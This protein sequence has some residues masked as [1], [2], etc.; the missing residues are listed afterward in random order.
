MTAYL[1]AVRSEFA[2]FFS[3]RS[4]WILL[5]VMVGYLAAIAGIIGFVVGFASEQLSTGGQPAE[6]SGAAGVVYS[7]AT[8]MGYVFPLLIGALAV[9][10]EFRHNTLTPTFLAIPRRG[11]VLAGKATALA[12]V[13]AGYGIAALIGTMGAGSALLAI[14]GVDTE[15]GST[16]TWAMVGRIILAMALWAV[17]GVGVGSI[18]PNQV[19]SIVIVLALTQFIEPILRMGSMLSE[20]TAS[21]SR[22]LPGSASDSLVG[23]SIYTLMSGSAHPNVTPLEWWQGGVVLAAIALVLLVIGA[24]T[25]WRRDLD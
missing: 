10:G 14:G 4:W 18:V 17:V 12:I 9:T 21:L 2:K 19:A 1:R 5:L 20:V 3:T 8:S 23:S 6:L 25:S 13:G 15:L 11:A 16:D 24:W 7:L 22:F